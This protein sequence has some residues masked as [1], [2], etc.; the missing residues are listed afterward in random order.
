MSEAPLGARAEWTWEWTVSGLVL[1]GGV[2]LLATLA[3]GVLE[4]GPVDRVVTY[5]LAFGSVGGI[6]SAV[7]CAVA[8]A[9]ANAVTTALWQ[10]AP[11]LALLLG[12]F[13]GVGVGSLLGPALAVVVLGESGPRVLRFTA[14][15]GGACAGLIVAPAW[16]AYVALRA[17]GRAGL[18]ALGLACVWAPV[19]VASTLAMLRLLA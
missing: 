15:A 6:A 1:G 7:L 3:L 17:R 14:L 2:P 19:P 13:V 10:R 4:R 11:S 18:P 16:F 12:P 5:A 9:P 8:A